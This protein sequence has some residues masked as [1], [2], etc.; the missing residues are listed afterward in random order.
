VE[1]TRQALRTRIGGEILLVGDEEIAL[2]AAFHGGPGI[3]IIAGTG[4]NAVGRCAQGKL[5]RAGGWGPVLGDEGSGQWIGL[6][7]IRAALRAHDRGVD[8]CLLREI[9]EAWR[10]KD[11]GELVA[12]SNQRSRPDFSEL[13]TTVAR[14]AE[15]GDGLA[16]SVLDRAGEELA[17]I[18]S[19]VASKMAGLGCD[20]ADA[21]HVAFTGSV[22]T[23][24]A[25]VRRSFTAHL[26]TALPHAQVA[27]DPAEP[28]EG[29]LWR[30]R[31]G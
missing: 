3:M 19:L 24:I 28:L 25:A 4:S 23:R 27:Q 30:A 18:V 13:A 8:T 21:S 11:L 7:A 10:L 20:P 15:N 1:W 22:L 5:T 12:A 26:A 14:C 16:Q 2:D 6:E 17:G 29:A 9:E 31:K